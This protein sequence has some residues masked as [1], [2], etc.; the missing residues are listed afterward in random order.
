M[1]S[2]KLGTGAV[3]FAVAGFLPVGG[4]Q[5][6]RVFGPHAGQARSRSQ[7]LDLSIFISRQTKCDSNQ[8]PQ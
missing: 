1:T 8:V 2:M 5:L 3:G 7:T 6:N 4:S